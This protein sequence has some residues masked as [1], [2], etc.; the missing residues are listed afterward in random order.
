MAESVKIGLRLKDDIK[1][2][3]KAYEKESYTGIQ[4]MTLESLDPNGAYR[5]YRANKKMS[6]RL[7]S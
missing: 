5:N 4:K 3:K 6:P 1:I 7:A 2:V